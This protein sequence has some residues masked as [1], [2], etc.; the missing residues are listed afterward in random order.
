MNTG[1][2]ACPF[3]DANGKCCDGRVTGWRLY[4]GQTIYMARK[5]RLWC[6]LKHDHCGSVS[7]QAGKDRMEF[8]PNELPK[9]VFEAIAIAPHQLA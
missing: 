6:S 1:K 8:Y 7:S 9:Q 5:V 3:V 4:G 2:L